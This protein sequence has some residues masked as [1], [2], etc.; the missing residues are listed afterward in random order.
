MSIFQTFGIGRTNPGRTVPVFDAALKPNELLRRADLIAVFDDPEDICVNEGALFVAD[1]SCLLLIGPEKIAQPVLDT[2]TKITAFTCFAGGY[3][4]ALDGQE[5]V[6]F[7]GKYDGCRLT[8]PANAPF[9]SINAIAV[10]GSHLLVTD[11]STTH[12][13][14]Q[15]R[16]DAMG[17]GNSGRLLRCDLANGAVVVLQEGLEFSFG[18]AAFG[19]G[20][21]VSETWRHRLVSVGCN[22][23]RQIVLD[24]LPA[25]PSRIAK[26]KNGYWLTMFCARSQIVEFVLA[27]REYCDAMIEEIDPDLWISP[28]VSASA[29]PHE[30]LQR[31]GMMMDSEIK[32]W[33]PARTYGLVVKLNPDGQPQ[34]SIHSRAG[35]PNQG[36]IAAAEMGGFLYLI[37]KSENTLIRLGVDTLESEINR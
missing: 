22:G 37:S 23:E 4:C 18:T 1:G 14:D 16:H 15:W 35:G 21:L 2:G 19:G 20:A 7:G 29:S 31:A 26:A 25:Y 24:H 9:S 13:F 12:T 10:Q 33:A 5:I 27:E 34:Y 8:G 32:P 11:G 17:L 36:I 3:V 30:P 6:V 28:Q